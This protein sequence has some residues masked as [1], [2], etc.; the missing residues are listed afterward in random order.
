VT[1]VAT[2]PG[3]PFLTKTSAMI[4]VTAMEHSGVV[5]EGFQ[6]VLFPAASDRAKFQP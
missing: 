2:A 4:F 1:R 5:G 3:I 6:M